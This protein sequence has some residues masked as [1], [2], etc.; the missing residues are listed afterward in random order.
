[1]IP[2]TVIN[3]ILGSVVFVCF[4]PM[5]FAIN[6]HALAVEEMNYEF[7]SRVKNMRK[8]CPSN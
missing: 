1:M 6:V 4:V 2:D 7:L 5:N 3:V 8:I